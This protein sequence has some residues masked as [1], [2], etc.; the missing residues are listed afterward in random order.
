MSKISELNLINQDFKVPEFLDLNIKNFKGISPISPKKQN[1]NKWGIR[2]DP[3]DNKRIIKV[4]YENE[5]ECKH[6][7]EI[8]KKAFL[9][10]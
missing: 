1:D 8:I 4:F 2:L 5:D 3:R 7:Y 10:R 9:N 6:D